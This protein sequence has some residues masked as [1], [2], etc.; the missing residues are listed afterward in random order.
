MF[1]FVASV[2]PLLQMRS[3]RQFC[4]AVRARLD[5]AD[6]QCRSPKYLT[7]A[8]DRSY[9]CDFKRLLQWIGSVVD[10][11]MEIYS[12]IAPSRDSSQRLELQHLERPESLAALCRLDDIPLDANPELLVPVA[13]A[14]G[15]QPEQFL[16]LMS[17]LQMWFY[18]EL[19]RRIFPRHDHL[20]E[21][22][23]AGALRL[24][25]RL[26]GEW[27]K[28]G[29][30]PEDV[31]AALDDPLVLQHE[32]KFYPSA[33][34]DALESED[35]NETAIAFLNEAAD[36][37]SFSSG[38]AY[39]HAV[40]LIKA[41]RIPDAVRELQRGAEGGCTESGRD[42]CRKTIEQLRGL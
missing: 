18:V 31:S 1:A 28:T 8:R 39:A 13:A 41:H 30:V 22:E 29:T 19:L 42:R 23:E 38:I 16:G 2:E 37:Y 17:R 4:D 36:R 40:V 26:T 34:L 32:L 12:A 20:H 9:D 11:T 6:S 33:V 27:L 14:R 15:A 25:K 7:P 35:A 21:W 3:G 24:Y 5:W 10:L